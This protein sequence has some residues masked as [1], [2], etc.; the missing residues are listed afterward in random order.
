MAYRNPNNVHFNTST[1]HDNIKSV[2][3]TISRDPSMYNTNNGKDIKDCLMRHGDRVSY[4]Y[5]PYYY[6]AYYNVNYYYVMPDS[7]YYPNDVNYYYTPSIYDRYYT[8]LAYCHPYDG[9]AI[10]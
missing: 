6:P 4:N 3:D 2:N 5:Y 8:S 9:Y 1:C 10:L 7:L